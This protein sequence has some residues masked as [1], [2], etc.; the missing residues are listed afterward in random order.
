MNKDSYLVCTAFESSNEV[1][2]KNYILKPHKRLELC[3]GKVWVVQSGGLSEC[4]RFIKDKQ[5]LCIHFI[6]DS[7]KMIRNIE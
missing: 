1:S 5:F 6:Y 4:W 7:V 2:M 3:K